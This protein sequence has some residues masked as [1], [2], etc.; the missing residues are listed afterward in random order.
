MEKSDSFK[1]MKKL[2]L[3]ILL[4]V[5]MVFVGYI[6]IWIMM[7]TNTFYLHWLPQIQVKTNSTY[8]GQQGLNS[9]E[10]DFVWSSSFF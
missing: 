6:L 2:K 1:G 4:F 10:H 8:F 7:P 3:A 5:I 9:V